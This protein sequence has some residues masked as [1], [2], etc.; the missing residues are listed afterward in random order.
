LFLLHRCPEKMIDPVAT[1]IYASTR[2]KLRELLEIRRQLT[3]KVIL[4]Y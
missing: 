2:V 4:N 3:L 1:T